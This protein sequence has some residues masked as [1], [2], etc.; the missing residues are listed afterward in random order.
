MTESLPNG[1]VG[2]VDGS[3][4]VAERSRTAR[5]MVDVVAEWQ[6][7]DGV[8]FCKRPIGLVMW[9]DP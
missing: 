9:L 7:A 5:L 3:I 8:K 6:P 4:L 1:G 2:E